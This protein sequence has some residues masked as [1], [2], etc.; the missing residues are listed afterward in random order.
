MTTKLTKTGNL[1]F[2]LI[3]IG[4]L[5]LCLGTFL[6]LGSLFDGYSARIPVWYYYISKTIAVGFA[7]ELLG[8]ILGLIC[9]VMGKK[10]SE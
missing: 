2:G 10:L 1:V 5:V 6:I 3:S 4:L 8:G 9:A 7:L